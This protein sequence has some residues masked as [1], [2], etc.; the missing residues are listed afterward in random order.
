[1]VG[2][3][4]GG[5]E[6][7]HVLPEQD[8]Q[9]NDI[10]SVNIQ[11]GR[12]ESSERVKGFVNC[13]NHANFH[14]NASGNPTFQTPNAV[15]LQA[16]NTTNAPEP[17]ST[18]LTGLSGLTGEMEGGGEY[19][20]IIEGPSSIDI[21]AASQQGYLQA[22]FTSFG[23]LD[24][25]GGPPNLGSYHGDSVWSWDTVQNDHDADIKLPNS[26]QAHCYITRLGGN[27]DGH[28]EYARLVVGEDNHWRL[29]VHASDA[30]KKVKVTARCIAY[31]QT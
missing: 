7:V 14:W 17:A 8:F 16:N 6:E 18:H 27:F 24:S 21:E 13:S 20:Q 19:G 22:W 9:N 31:D 5:G 26:D 29:R 12:T 4:A 10:W 23:P 25:A 2:K 3:F 1:M 30:P 28:A 15:G 11:S